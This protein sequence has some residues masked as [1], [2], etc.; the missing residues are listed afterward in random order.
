MVAV[1][2]S[3]QQVGAAVSVEVTQVNSN[4]AVAML[5]GRAWDDNWSGVAQ[6]RITASPSEAVGRWY[7]LCF[8]GDSNCR[9]QTRLMLFSRELEVVQPCVACY[10]RDT[11]PLKQVLWLNKTTVEV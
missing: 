10:G 1:V 8:A 4:R 7:G 3:T 11:Y 9:Q 2:P 5:Q 6:S